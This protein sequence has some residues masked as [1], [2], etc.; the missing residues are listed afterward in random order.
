M[1]TQI[2]SRVKVFV[3]T[4]ALIIATAL[5]PRGVAAAP[6][7]VKGNT[8][9]GHGYT[10]TT[11]SYAEWKPNLMLTNSS[12]FLNTPAAPGGIKIS[13]TMLRGMYSGADA[14]QTSHSVNGQRT[15][16]LSAANRYSYTTSPGWNVLISQG[17][18]YI[19][20][21]GWVSIYAGQAMSEVSRSLSYALNSAVT[22]SDDGEYMKAVG[23]NGI[24]GFV[25]TAEADAM[26]QI[27]DSDAVLAY[28]NANEGTHYIDVYDASKQVV[29]DKYP[30]TIDVVKK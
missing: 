27:V 18:A 8:Y 7:F 11:Q 14:S 9:S 2:N 30:V 6:S 22:Y 16:S 1:S 29:I 19:N 4:I 25:K 10:V 24:S 12:M 23:I 21:D 5:F 13:N 17:T 20:L 3:L 28:A 15:Q 26:A